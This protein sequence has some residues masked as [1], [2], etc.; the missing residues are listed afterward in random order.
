[1]TR[2]PEVSRF[3]VYVA[4][5]NDAP[6]AQHGQTRD[7]ESMLLWLNT[8][9]RTSDGKTGRAGIQQ[10]GKHLSCSQQIRWGKCDVNIYFLS[11]E[12][13]NSVKD[14]L[15]FIIINKIMPII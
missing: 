13:K 2:V 8:T 1:M 3:Q 4:W 11:E 14:Y 12:A 9:T 10:I 7:V 5:R 15:I 6:P